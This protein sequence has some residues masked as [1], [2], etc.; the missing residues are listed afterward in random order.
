LLGGGEGAVGVDVKE[1]VERGL[2]RLDALERGGDELGGR[3]LTAL[4]ERGELGGRLEHELGHG[5]AAA[6]SLAAGGERLRWR[7]RLRRLGR[8][9]VVP[10]GANF[11]GGALFIA[12]WKGKTP[13]PLWWSWLGG[14]GEWSRGR[15]WPRPG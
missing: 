7:G 10:A 12:I 11:R 2:K 1:G 13:N 8:A 14:S 5:L 15:S 6:Y 4:D 9:A 3:D